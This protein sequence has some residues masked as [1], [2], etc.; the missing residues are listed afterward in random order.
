MLLK[1]TTGTDVRQ[2]GEKYVSLVKLRTKLSPPTPASRTT[3]VYGASSR[4]V[5][6]LPIIGVGVRVAGLR[7]SLEYIVWPLLGDWVA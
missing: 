6:F 5:I 2:R 3:T 1:Q 7:C 4:G